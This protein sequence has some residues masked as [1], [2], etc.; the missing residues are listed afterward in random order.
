MH[1]PVLFKS[2]LVRLSPRSTRYAFIEDIAL[3]QY[4]QENLSLDRATKIVNMN[5][6]EFLDHCRQHHVEMPFSEIDAEIGIQQIESFDV[7]KYKDKITKNRK[8][9]EK[10]FE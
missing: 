2:R 7:R 10:H 8:L 5:L 3:E 9:K 6:W 4:T 1:T